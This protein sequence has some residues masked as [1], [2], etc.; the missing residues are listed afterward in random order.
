MSV[1]RLEQVLV[2]LQ[3]NCWLTLRRSVLADFALM[4]REIILCFQQNFGT[5]SIA[6][7]QSFHEPIIAWKAGSLTSKGI[8]HHAISIFE[9]FYES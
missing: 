6:P 8:C 9:S 4:L 3:T 5:C 2:M 1:L 7:M